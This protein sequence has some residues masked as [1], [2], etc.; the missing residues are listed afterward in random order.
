[1]TPS[2][3]SFLVDCISIREAFDR[4][5][6]FHDQ[7]PSLLDHVYDETRT[8][9]ELF[10][11]LAKPIVTSTLKGING[12]ILAYGQTSSGKV[13]WKNQIS[14]SRFLSQFLHFRRTQ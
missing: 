5:L 6:L 7:L 14:V 4:N 2:T 3:A 8:T 1:M 11:E 13:S 10:N 9:R 12:T